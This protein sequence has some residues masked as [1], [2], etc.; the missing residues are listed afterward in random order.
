MGLNKYDLGVSL[1]WTKPVKNDYVPRQLS[2]R[3]SE[4]PF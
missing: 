3:V 1:D 4:L 2:P